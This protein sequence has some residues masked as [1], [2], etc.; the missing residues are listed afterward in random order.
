MGKQTEDN[1]DILAEIGDEKNPIVLSM[2]KFKALRLF[3]IRRYYLDKKTKSIK[4]TPKGISIKEDEYHAMEQFIQKNSSVIRKSFIKDLSISEKKAVV[5][6]REKKTL[7]QKKNYEAKAS[8]ESWNGPI[9]FQFKE[10]G[11]ELSLALN[12]NRKKIREIE[13]KKITAEDLLIKLLDA[14]QNAKRNTH[15]QAS[16]DIDDFFEDFESNWGSFFK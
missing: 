11:G 6:R 4:P 8:Y 15:F 7:E 3:D 13:E 16:K 14:Y 9:F 12:R 5:S 1:N 10:K 2:N